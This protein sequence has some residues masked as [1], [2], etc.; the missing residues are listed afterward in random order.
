[1]LGSWLA[2]S[3]LS[4]VSMLLLLCLVLRFMLP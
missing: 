2:L 4:M 1:M 3:L